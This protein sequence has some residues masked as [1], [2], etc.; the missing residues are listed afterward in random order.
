MDGE[1]KNFVVTLCR[2]TVIISYPSPTRA[3]THTEKTTTRDRTDVR[4]NNGGS[5]N[6]E[7][8]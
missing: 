7:N 6:S 4:E 1:G 5:D 8:D 3:H 2:R